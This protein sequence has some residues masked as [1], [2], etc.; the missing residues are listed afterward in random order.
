M[1]FATWSRRW[2][3]GRGINRTDG[4]VSVNQRLPFCAKNEHKYVRKVAK[5]LLQ[6]GSSL[7]YQPIK[8]ITLTMVLIDSIKFW[9]EQAVI[10]LTTPPIV[11]C[12]KLSF[13]NTIMYSLSS[14]AIKENYYY[15]YNMALYCLN[16]H[17]CCAIIYNY[18]AVYYYYYYYYN[19]SS[20]CYYYA[21]FYIYISTNNYSSRSY[22][23]HC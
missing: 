1:P 16:L 10:H 22:I 5:S 20:N 21:H 14:S 12:T 6:R 3:S 2:S 11:I 4:N 9:V 19:N 7:Y 15:F 23:Q 13:N 8:A 18:S 17:L